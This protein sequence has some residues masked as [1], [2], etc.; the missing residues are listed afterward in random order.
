MCGPPGSGTSYALCPQVPAVR[1]Q[2]R[3][4]RGLPHR[5]V[6][7]SRKLLILWLPLQDMRKM[8]CVLH[9]KRKGPAG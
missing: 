3:G 7:R 5:R 2:H 6:Q 1:R 9:N 4:G 8:L